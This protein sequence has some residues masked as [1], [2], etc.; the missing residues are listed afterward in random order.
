MTVVGVVLII[1]AALVGVA[2]LTGGTDSTVLL[3]LGLFEVSTSV[4]GVF[5]IGAAT[6]LTFAAGLELLRLG[7]GR[8]LARRRELRHARALVA[9]HERREQMP[10]GDTDTDTGS[11]TTL[12]GRPAGTDPDTGSAAR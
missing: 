3:D 10:A 5:L 12:P 7:M 6:A 1:L 9:E 8:S 2:T 11:D 4:R